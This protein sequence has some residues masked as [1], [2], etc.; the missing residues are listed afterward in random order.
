VLVFEGSTIEA[1]EMPVVQSPLR[2]AC[3]V[4]RVAGG[5]LFDERF[6]LAAF[7]AFG[8]KDFTACGDLLRRFMQPGSEE[9]GAA[10]G[11]ERLFEAGKTVDELA[12]DGGAQNQSAPGTLAL[13]GGGQRAFKKAKIAD[14]G[15]ERAAGFLFFEVKDAK[16]A[17]EGTRGRH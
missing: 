14:G 3:R 9:S 2:A 13:R 11:S 15:L 10:H 12:G 16:Q 8:E 1:I 6:G 4:K 17:V 5:G 7:D